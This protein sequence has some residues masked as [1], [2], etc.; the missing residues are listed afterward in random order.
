MSRARRPQC[1]GMRHCGVRAA[2]A[3]VRAACVS[4]GCRMPHGVSRCDWHEHRARAPLA[5]RQG[6][7]AQERH[8]SQDSC[9]RGERVVSLDRCQQS[10]AR[11]TVP[12]SFSSFS[13]FTLPLLTRGWGGG[14]TN[15]RR[16][17]GAHHLVPSTSVHRQTVRIVTRSFSFRRQTHTFSALAVINS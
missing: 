9:R 10:P 6:R 17:G 14:T 15:R 13:L 7:A 16:V 4:E 5:G 11:C 8:T 1:A 12:A 2:C 3:G